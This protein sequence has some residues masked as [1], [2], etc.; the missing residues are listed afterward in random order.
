MLQKFQYVQ[1]VVKGAYNLHLAMRFNKPAQLLLSQNFIFYNDD[2]H[3]LLRPTAIKTGGHEQ[4]FVH[5]EHKT[6][7]RFPAQGG[8]YAARRHRGV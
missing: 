7:F 2:F 6:Q 8:E 4:R 3:L 5:S 1:T